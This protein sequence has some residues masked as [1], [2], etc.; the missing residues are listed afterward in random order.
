MYHVSVQSGVTGITVDGA[1]N[2]YYQNAETVSHAEQK[3]DSR[4][5]PAT[6]FSVNGM[7]CA[8]TAVNR[9]P[10]HPPKKGEDTTHIHMGRGSEC[11]IT[12]NILLLQSESDITMSCNSDTKSCSTIPHSSLQIM[13]PPSNHYNTQS[14]GLLAWTKE[15]ITSQVG[16]IPCLIGG[17]KYITQY[18]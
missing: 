4:E 5:P 12:A 18:R 1:Y 7:L 8:C 15:L 2:T 6:E 17:P 10:C 11:R 13:V 9:Y 14:P 16:V 3:L